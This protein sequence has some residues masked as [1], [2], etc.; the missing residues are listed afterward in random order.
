MAHVQFR[1][2]DATTNGLIAQLIV[3]G[4]DITEHVLEDGFEIKKFDS[5]ESGEWVV[6]MRL[7]AHLD[8][9]LPDAVVQAAVSE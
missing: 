9:D 1:T 5:S 2:G 8:V 3:D 6:Q 4:V 7:A